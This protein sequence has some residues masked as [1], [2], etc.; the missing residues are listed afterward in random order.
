MIYAKT[1]EMIQKYKLK[2]KSKCFHADSNARVTNK[3]SQQLFQK[4]WKGN[5]ST[6]PSRLWKA[7]F[8]SYPIY[9]VAGDYEAILTIKSDGV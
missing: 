8:D 9:A 4:D 5:N 2:W 6:V 3:K 7:V 1:A